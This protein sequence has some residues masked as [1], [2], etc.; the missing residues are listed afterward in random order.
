M[1]GNFFERG[2]KKSKQESKPETP[3]EKLNRF[4][5]EV[6]LEKVGLIS[7]LRERYT[8][9]REEG[10][11]IAISNY[12]FE[13]WDKILKDAGIDRNDKEKVTELEKEYPEELIIQKIREQVEGMFR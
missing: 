12:K 9:N 2:P 8:E 3:E 5:N 7:P 4:I 11:E 10:I 1:F 6:I 13:V